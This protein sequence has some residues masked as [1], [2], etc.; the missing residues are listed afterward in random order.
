M[1]QTLYYNGHIYTME[2]GDQCRCEAVLVADGRILGA[3]A[4]AAMEQL[5]DAGVRRV[6]LEGK[7]LLPSFIDPHSH[8]SMLANTLHA[9]P[10]GDCTSYRQ[11]VQRLREAVAS[12]NLEPGQWVVGFGYDH[13]RLEEGRHPTRQVL[14][15]VS[16]T[17][18]VLITHQSGH[19]GVANTIA[20]NEGGYTP[21][22]PDPEG[23]K[24][25][26]DYATGELSGYL[27]ENAFI[28]FSSSASGLAPTFAQM[29]ALCEKAQEVYLK[30]G[31]TTAQEGMVKHQ[32][33]TLLRTLAE[34]GS[35]KLDLVGYV[36]LKDEAEIAKENPEYLR[37][38]RNRLKIGGY[39]IFLDGSPQG[40]TA[41]LSAPYEGERDGY[42]GYP[43][44]KDAEVERFCKIAMGEGM[45][46]LCHCNGDAASQQYLDAFAAAK[47]ALPD[48]DTCR[49]VMIHAQTVRPGDQLPRMKELGMMPSYF[50]AHTYFWGDTHLKNLGQERATRI[51]PAASTLKAGIPFTFH[52]DTPVLEPD[53]L[54]TVWCAVNRISL[55]GADMGKA[56]RISP[57][58]ALKAVTINAAYQYFEE[59]EKGSIAPGKLAN[60]VILDQDPM[61][62]DPMAICDIRVVETIR[63][64]E[65]LYRA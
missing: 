4:L 24:I 36:D 27:E 35:L 15:Q 54:R 56:E 33:F 16:S 5:A 34:H 60:L 25:G 38:Y 32:N 20:L 28:T 37:Q 12:G 47:A 2:P 6:D 43:I 58:E 62:V 49:P 14:D 64:G 61:E 11:I 30:H 17:R 63:E 48:K 65:T 19:M 53:M 18:P 40:K 42:C 44:Y 23:G 51:S 55:S 31:I 50:V 9:V 46:L 45:Q 59:D 57:L 8:L 26:R 29:L 7:T 13:N 1:S 52:Q 10:L 41:W 21:Q 39:K 3:G 22:T